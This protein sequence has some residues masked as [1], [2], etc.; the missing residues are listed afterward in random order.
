MKS[1]F[2]KLFGNRNIKRLEGAVLAV[3]ERGTAIGLLSDEELKNVSLT[4][5]HRISE[6]ADPTAGLTEVLPEAFALVREAA[7]RTL[8]QRHYDVQL[9]GGIALHEGNIAQMGTGEGKTLV[10]TLPA[11][12]NALTGNGVHVITVND[13]LAKRDAVWMG[14]VYYALGLSVSCISHDSAFRY[15]PSFVPAELDQERDLLGTFK[16]VDKFLRPV[17]RKEAYEADITYG[18]NHEFGFDYLRD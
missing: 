5:K 16:I 14:Q 12:L 6:F 1:L 17:T 10:A 15:D 13:Y 2:E 3:R 8:K 4:L 9:M 7:S 18:T 11:Y